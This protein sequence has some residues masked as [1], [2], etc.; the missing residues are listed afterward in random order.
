M[1]LTQA[2]HQLSKAFTE[3]LHF[4]QHQR[5]KGTDIPYIS[6]LMAVASL[7][8]ENG[9]SEDEVIAALLHD[10]G[11][12]AG[13]DDALRIIENFFG[14]NVAS[15]VRELSDTLED[16][17][18]PWRPRK[19]AYVAHLEEASEGALRICLADRLH[20]ARCT[21]ADA[22]DVGPKVWERFNAGREE[23]LWYLHQV[24]RVLNKRLPCA[25]SAEL[26]CIL[27]EIAFV[28]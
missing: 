21:L 11:E 8:M 20:N 6:H 23:Q 4:H 9:G 25:Q 2:S 22:W 12:D 14:T 10:A 24:A 28:A 16:P 1:P 15:L 19:E 27:K 26:I 18:P 7:V 17:K 3:A 5:R 13:G